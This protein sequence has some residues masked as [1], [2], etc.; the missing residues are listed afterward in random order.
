MLI[1]IIV[2]II[3]IIMIMIWPDRRA[4]PGA[5]PWL[6]TWCDRGKASGRAGIFSGNRF[7]STAC[8]TQAFFKSDE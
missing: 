1:I 3:V 6:L 8:L 5:A 2:I 4:T 7:S